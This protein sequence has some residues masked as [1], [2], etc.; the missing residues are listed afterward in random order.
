MDPN[1]SLA[2]K[3]LEVEI[4][5]LEEQLS[6]KRK[7]KS[8]SKLE[9]I[10]SWIKRWSVTILTLV[11]IIG[12][13]WGLIL[14]IKSYYDER[15]KALKYTL[16]SQ[17]VQLVN[18][19]KTEEEVEESIMM[20]QY[21]EMN[22]LDILLFKLERAGSDTL[23]R[24]NI[25]VAVNNIYKKNHPECIEPLASNALRHLRK[26]YVNKTI[27]ES[28]FRALMNYIYVINELECDGSD[29]KKLIKAL[30]P[31]YEAVPQSESFNAARRKLEKI[32]NRTS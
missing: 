25:S 24:N 30:N 2:N 20:L 19:L 17:M 9:I 22:S 1:Q 28:P 18:G 11:S 6:E 31:L 8:I 3:K 13:V 14:P 10:N 27:V 15:S 12:G 26:S 5:L 16:N 7:P 4:Q 23:L 21:Y 29:Q 32:I